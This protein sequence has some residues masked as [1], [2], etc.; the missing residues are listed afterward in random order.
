MMHDLI[1]QSV[2]LKKY[3]LSVLISKFEKNR[4]EDIKTQANI[5]KT[6]QKIKSSHPYNRAHAMIVGWTGMP[7]VGKSSLLHAVCMNMLE[8]DENLRIG[9]LAIDPTSHIS[10][11]SLLG[12]RTRI[13]L[14]VKEN[15]IFFRSQSTELILGGLGKH[16]FSVSLLL[17]ELFDLLF[18]ET[19]GIGQNEIEIKLLAEFVTLIIQPF[20]GDEIQFIKAGIMEIPDIFVLNKCDEKNL[21]ESSYRKLLHSLQLNHLGDQVPP[22]FKTSTL[23][24]TG[25]I[26]LSECILAKMHQYDSESEKIKKRKKNEYFLIKLVKEKYGEYGV[27]ILLN[28]KKKANYFEDLMSILE[29]IETFVQPLHVALLFV[30]LLT[31]FHRVWFLS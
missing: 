13:R 8:K 11:G 29:K 21:A 26:D 17:Q 20:A 3:P 12:D 30:L 16:T 15:R 23:N 24:Q 31:I 10:G 5:L 27:N 18:I 6:I 14:P 7:G 1:E 28:Q 25:I 4:V 22:V 19:V 9:I 2:C